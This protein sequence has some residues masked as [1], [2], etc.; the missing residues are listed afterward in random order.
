MTILHADDVLEAGYVEASIAAH[1]RW[2][3]AACVATRATVIDVV[4]HRMSTLADLVKRCMWPRRATE[5]KG[6]AGLRRLLRGQFLYCPAVSYR[7]TLLPKPAWNERWKQVMDLELYGR[8]LLDG[9][10]IRLQSEPLYRYRRHAGATTAVNSG[11]LV[12][13]LEETEVC[14]EL[15]VFAQRAGWTRAARAG[16]ARLAV[17][18][19]ALTQAA[20]LLRRRQWATLRTAAGYVLAR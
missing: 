13:T 9:H 14:R 7:L 16:R 15:A 8:L 17:R 11:N 18:G 6:E 1:A 19:Q 10:S 5:L 4:G 20:S 2:P 3:E 12:R